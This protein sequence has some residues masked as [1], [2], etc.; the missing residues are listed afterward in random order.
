MIPRHRPYLRFIEGV[1]SLSLLLTHPICDI[2]AAPAGS[3]FMRWGQSP[4]RRS[5]KRCRCP[6]CV[7]DARRS[8]RI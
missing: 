5:A 6:I 2:G 3:A 4:D 8:P 7:G 1:V